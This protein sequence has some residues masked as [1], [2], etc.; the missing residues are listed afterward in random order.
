M[1]KLF[2]KIDWVWFVSGLL[3]ALFVL[4]MLQGFIAAR[5]TPAAAQ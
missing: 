4:P 3:F 2:G 1:G 5:R